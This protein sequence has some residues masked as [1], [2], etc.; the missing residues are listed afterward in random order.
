[1]RDGFDYA[2]LIVASA[3]LMLSILNSLYQI[4]LQKRRIKVRLS[5]ALAGPDLSQI[6]NSMPRDDEVEDRLVLVV[7]IVNVSQRP[8]TVTN[9]TVGLNNRMEYVQFRTLL[10]ENALPQLVTDGATIN[11]NFDIG[12]MEIL[13][14]DFDKGTYFNGINVSDAEGN[15]YKAKLPR[16]FRQRGLIAPKRWYQF[17]AK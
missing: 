4:R 1:M 12:R 14:S 5:V 10:G 8:I 11:F 2:T 9:I 3:A 15:V 13:L 17:W 16:N 6:R 7:A